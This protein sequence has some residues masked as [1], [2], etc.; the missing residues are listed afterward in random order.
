MATLEWIDHRPHRAL[1]S[2]AGV[3]WVPVSAAKVIRGL[4]QLCWKT[5]VPW[6][7]A[8]LWALERATEQEV[9]L[10]TVHA[11]MTALHAYAK[12]LE[13]ADVH[14]WDF[15]LKKSGRCLVRYRKALIESRDC[16]DLAPSTASQRMAV[17]VQFYRWLNSTALLSSD[18]PM[19]RERLIS[20]H[21]TDTVGFTRTISVRSTDLAIQ[22]RK[23]PGDRLEDGWRHRQAVS[24]SL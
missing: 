2:E 9:R 21:L 14:W 19:W 5:G 17:V 15:P 6:R 10:K 16:G 7:E 24:A 13:A 4:P 22:N 8:N 3:Q 18:G 20:I 1:V 23:A 12:W 11:G